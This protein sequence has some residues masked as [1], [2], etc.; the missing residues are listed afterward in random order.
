[1]DLIKIETLIEKYF[2]ATTSIAEENVLRDYF[3]N[4]NVA[5][6]LEEYK[7][8]FQ[9]QIKEQEVTFNRNINWSQ[10]NK[11]GIWLSIAASFIVIL[12]VI[13]FYTNDPQTAVTTS[14][15][16][17]YNDPEHAFKETQK[18]LALLSSNVNV[19]INSVE[20][21]HEFELAKNR[22]FKKSNQ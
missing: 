16:G 3:S 22:V 14:D 12:G 1:M 21:L 10:K 7:S 15:L 20:H 8:L 5:S 18:A 4:A 11:K 19:G 6:H 9:Y 13:A 17:S 2:E